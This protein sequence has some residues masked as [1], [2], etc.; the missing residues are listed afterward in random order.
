MNVG[1]Y[2]LVA[3]DAC[4]GGRLGLRD[5]GGKV[6]DCRVLDF[7]GGKS[8]AL[9]FTGGKVIVLL[10][11]S[12]RS[13]GLIRGWYASCGEG[14]STEKE[15]ASLLLGEGRAGLGAN[16]G[17]DPFKEERTLFALLGG[18]CIY[19]GEGRG[20]VE[21]LPGELGL[22]CLGDGASGS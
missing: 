17:E 22:D 3:G 12:E 15:G 2:V 14:G 1:L 21:T 4:R 6:G 5:A 19:D 9:L 18:E 7:R 13:G 16:L 20:E 11:L 8:G 10:L